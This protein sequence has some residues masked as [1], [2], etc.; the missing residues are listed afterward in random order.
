MGMQKR[1]REMF[2]I[3]AFS[4][5]FAGVSPIWLEASELVLSRGQTVYVPVYSNVIVGPK[6]VPIYLSNTLI[7]RNTDIHNDI[8][9]SLADYYDT[10]GSLIRKFYAQPVA[11]K[12]LQ[13]IYLY[14][15]D[16]DR[17]G[18][19]GA[20]FIVRWQAEKEVNA[21]IIECV[22]VGSRGHTLVSTS[23]PIREDRK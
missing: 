11:L 16:R 14:L 5:L 6:E 2:G 9:V 21:P 23:R 22:T 19:V 10:K 7:I 13:T 20:N 3:L 15:S 12:P 17:E 8:Q 18:G 4:L 1:L